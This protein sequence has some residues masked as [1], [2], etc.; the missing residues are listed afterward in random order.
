VDPEAGLWTMNDHRTGPDGGTGVASAV[1]LEV[2]VEP[3]AQAFVPFFLGLAISA[4]L[5]VPIML[6]LR[7]SVGEARAARTGAAQVLARS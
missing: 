6:R 3:G 2:S 1:R 4:G 5:L 7:S